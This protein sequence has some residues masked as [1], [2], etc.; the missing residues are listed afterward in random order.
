[1]LFFTQ[2]Q[3]TVTTVRNTLCFL[4]LLH[5]KSI[6]SYI[7]ISVDYILESI[8]GMADPATTNKN[9]YIMR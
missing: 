4:W 1:M 6:S 7:K 2:R 3:H 8:A 5:N 9:Y